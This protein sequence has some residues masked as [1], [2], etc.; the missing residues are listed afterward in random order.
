M[1]KV[2]IPKY[3]EKMTRRDREM[4]CDP[5]IYK[6]EEDKAYYRHVV[7]PKTLL[8]VFLVHDYLP[9]KLKQVDIMAML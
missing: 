6:D 2:V 4:L 7:K 8:A 1:Q 5:L 3:G 9:L